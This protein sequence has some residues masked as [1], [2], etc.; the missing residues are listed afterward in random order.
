MRSARLR[1][2]WYETP[3]PQHS[4]GLPSAFSSQGG[5][6]TANTMSS[7]MAALGIAIPGSVSISD[8]SFLFQWA[9]CFVETA[10]APAVDRANKVVRA[11]SGK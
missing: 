5:M 1:L 8:A 7:V 4:I 11:L 2:L 3:T 6:F 10:S 9:P